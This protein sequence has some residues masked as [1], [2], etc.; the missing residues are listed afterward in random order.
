MICFTACTLLN[1]VGDW[2]CSCVRAR[3]IR[4][5]NVRT[6]LCDDTSRGWV[7][8]QAANSESVIFSNKNLNILGLVQIVLCYRELLLFWASE[9]WFHLS[10]LLNVAWTVFLL[11]VLIIFFLWKWHRLFK[12]KHHYP[13][14][15]F[16]LAEPPLLAHSLLV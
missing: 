10:T 14:A 13:E 9:V 7:Q 11:L 5:S 1:R 16:P 6:V 2:T 3:K 15:Q 8:K 4:V 12:W